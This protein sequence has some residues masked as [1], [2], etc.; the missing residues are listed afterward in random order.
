MAVFGLFL[1]WRVGATQ[2]ALLRLLI[3]VPSAVAEHGSRAQAW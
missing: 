1:V 2:V 3:A